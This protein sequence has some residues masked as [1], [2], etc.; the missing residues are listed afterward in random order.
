MSVK[1]GEIR[2]AAKEFGDVLK[3]LLDEKDNKKQVMELLKE[4]MEAGKAGFMLTQKMT[5]DQKRAVVVR[6]A[7]ALGQ[8]VTDQVLPLEGKSA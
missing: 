8:Y 5:A 3:L 4:V 2:E 6:F 1:Q 7:L